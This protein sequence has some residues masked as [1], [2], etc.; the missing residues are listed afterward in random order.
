MKIFHEKIISKIIYILI[1]LPFLSF[2][3]TTYTTILYF[4]TDYTFNGIE[5]TGEN[6][7]LK[8]NYDEGD[9]VINDQLYK[10]EISNSFYNDIITLNLLSSNSSDYHIGFLVQIQDKFYEIQDPELTVMVRNN[11]FDCSIDKTFIQVN[12]TYSKEVKYCKNKNQSSNVEFYMYIPFNIYE[13]CYSACT[14]CSFFGN[15]TNNNCLKCNNSEN[16]YFKE[17]DNSQNCYTNDTIEE[18][19]F[20]DEDNSIFKKC[21]NSCLT[22]SNFSENCIK[23]NNNLDYHFDPIIDNHCIKQDELPNINYYL[24]IIDDKYKICNERCLECLGPN[25]TQCKSC[26]NSNGYYS[27]EDD[28]NIICYS[29]DE[30]EEGYYLDTNNNIIKQCYNRCLSCNESGTN[31][32]NNCVKCKNDEYH[33]DPYKANHCINR[34]ELPNINYYLDINDDKYKICNERCLE[35]EG[36]NETQC[37][38]CNNS[39]GYYSKEDDINII[40]YSMEEIENGYY[41]DIYNNIIKKC[42]NRCFSCNKGGSD[43]NSNCLQCLNNEYHFDP[44]KSNHCINESELP[45]I[46]YYLDKSINKYKKCNIACLTC[47]GPY[48][49][50]CILCDNDNGYYYKENNESQICYSQSNIEIGYYLDTINNLFRNCNNRCLSCDKGG[51]DIQSN[52]IKCNKNENYHFDP[53]IDNH[54]IKE[55]ELPNINYYLDTIDDKYKICL[56]SCLTCAGPSKCAKCNNTKGYYFIENDNSGICYTQLT[57]PIGYYLNLTDN[58]FKLCNNRCYS[59][60]RGGNNFESN[61]TVCKNSANYHFD[62]YKLDHCI[63]QSELPNISFYLE[64]SLDQYKICHESCLTCDGQYN[65]NCTSCNGVSFFETEFYDKRCLKFEE[66]PIN[67]YSEYSSGKFVYYKCHISCKTCLVG[68]VNNCK[69]CNISGGY[70]PVSD[71]PGYCLTENQ[72]PIKYYLDRTE[73]KIKNCEANCATC[74]KGFNSLT[75]EMNCDSC[76]PNT[77]FQNTTSTNCIPKPETGFYIDIYNGHETLFPCFPTCLTC[78]VGGD[79]DINNCLSCRSEYY[80]DDEE[81]SNC[82]DDDLN[83]AIGCAKC[84]KNSSD[85]VYGVLSADKMCRR[86]SHKMG[87]YPLEKYSPNQFYVSCYP[88]NKSPFNYIYDENKKIHTLCYK[89]CKTCF[90]VG[91]NLNHS[92][93]SCETNYIFIDEEQFNCFPKCEFYYYYNKY[94]QYKCTE[95]SE[96]PLEYP[97]LISN[98]SKCVDN[99]YSDNEFNLMFKNECFQKC[100]EGTSAYLYKYNGEFTAKCI[101]SDDFLDDKECDLDIKV[102]KLKYSEITEDILDEYAADYVHSYPVANSYVTSYLSPDSDTMNKYLIVIYKLE[103]CPKQKVEGFIPIGL[104]ECIDKVKTKFTIMQNIVVEI[105]YIIRKSTAPQINYYLYHPDTGEKLDLSVCSGAKLAIKTSIFDNGKVDEE[106]VK[107]F[108]N[109]GINIFD[110]KDPFFT[111]I[112]FNYNQQ[113][114]D[115]TLEDRIRLYYQNITLCEDGC[116]YIG[117][118]LENYEVECSCDVKSEDKPIEENNIKNLLDNPISNEVFGVITNSNLE[119]LKCIKY[120]FNI[121]LILK[122]YGGLSMMGVFLIQVICT[123]FIK[124]QTKKVERFIYKFIT[125]IKNPPKRKTH[126][127]NFEKNKY[128]KEI[129]NKNIY[130]VNNNDIINKASKDIIINSISKNDNI[131]QNKDEINNKQLK[132][133]IKINKKHKTHKNTNIKY[134]NP[135]PKYQLLKQGS[136]SSTSSLF[137]T[138]DKFIFVKKNSLPYT[139]QYTNITKEQN[140]SP[141]KSGSELNLNLNKSNNSSGNDSGSGSGCGDRGSTRN[142]L[143]L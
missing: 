1:V 108:S 7:I 88:F 11:K 45:S 43:S 143:L 39:N 29:I 37:L 114:K 97:F 59:C 18:G 93:S 90:K 26:N 98:K 77:Y 121:K 99:C 13:N 78:D 115:V 138:K 2:S 71:K 118:N 128:N 8:Y 113:G 58:L 28:I 51:S 36:P 27:K 141:N 9:L 52:C 34:D 24:D 73:K 91:D 38:S 22:C 25:E 103:K 109:L 61:C 4:K 84:Y 110:I 70:Y 125:Q 63:K 55:E 123:I 15:E 12:E 86:C 89:T 53:Y 41:L 130:N 136:L 72:V 74:S 68:G 17:E 102:S 127:I 132:I 96:C 135:N 137:G 111:D 133:D 95:T 19:Y 66:I 23:C 6:N 119:V 48:N 112:C 80:F 32:E 75:Q 60:I 31:E 81:P 64:T 129:N 47:Y 106:L 10:V 79:A 20:L 42:N 69:D 67:Y 134:R 56:P 87:Y 85:P 33:F 92:C 101:N 126:I 100:P 105:F 30:I 50:N 120:A 16:Y 107:Y 54:C 139:T 14:E 131:E 44:I 117:V 46:S 65:N 83:C 3:T 35:C 82:V 122:N 94:N 57:I 76:I 124:I 21:S 5:H 49:N 104:D 142:T 62:P 140:N 116:S 40:C